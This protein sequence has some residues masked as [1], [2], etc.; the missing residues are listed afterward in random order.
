VTAYNHKEAF[1]HMRYRCE[2]CLVTVSI[3]N[4][5]DGVTPFS[6]GRCEASP[7][8]AGEMVHAAPWSDDRCEPDYVPAFGDLVFIDMPEGI[9]QI[10]ASMRLRQFEGG[11]YGRERGS[12]DWKATH[13]ALVKDYTHPGQP[14]LLGTRGRSLV[15]RLLAKEPR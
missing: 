7:V 11:A 6:I 5:R 8:C 12:D 13:A 10:L 4:S 9:A 2:L 14:Y 3:W 15:D 1:C